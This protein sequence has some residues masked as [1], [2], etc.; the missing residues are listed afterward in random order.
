MR[1]ITLV[2]LLVVC[3]LFSFINCQPTC[4]SR[5]GF[6]VQFIYSSGFVAFPTILPSQW[7]SNTKIGFEDQGPGATGQ[8]VYQLNVDNS[9]PNTDLVTIS[10][11]SLD[12]S[13]VVYLCNLNY[14][15]ST[16]LFEAPSNCTSSSV[17]TPAPCT[18]NSQSAS[19]ASGQFSFV[20]TAAAAVIAY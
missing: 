16:N 20:A 7:N 9:V 13:S 4:T 19:C 1:S 18:L 14:R 12:T 2:Q 3:A 17:Q 11:V 8:V 5:T 6:A 10:L 15:Q